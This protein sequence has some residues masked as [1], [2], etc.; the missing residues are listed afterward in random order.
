MKK[1][2]ATIL[3]LSFLACASGVI[4]NAKS[5]YA[6]ETALTQNCKSAYLCDFNS[7]ECI[8][9]ENETARMPI[10]SVCK[11]MT[12]T[13]CFDAIQSGKLSLDDKISVSE[14]AAGMG[15]SQ[16]FLQTGLTYPLSDLIK[17][18]IVCSANDSC[19]AVSESISG[20]EEG[21]VALM[22]KR[23]EELGCTDTLFANC[24]GLPKET[25]YSCAKDVAIM[26]SN[27][28][29]NEE[30]FKYSKIWLEDFNHPDNRTTSITNTNK[31]IRKYTACDGG[32][33]GFT[34]QAGF[35]LA[36]TA[37]KDSMRLVSVVLGASSS[38]DRFK[39]AMNMFDYGFANYKNRVI[40]DKDVNLNDKFTVDCSKK[41]AISVK[42]ARSSYVFSAINATP[43]IERNVIAYDIKAPVKQGDVVG[44]IEVYKDGVLC[45]TVDLVAAEDA[46][47]ATYGDFFKKVARGWTL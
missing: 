43:E 31:L 35:C 42:P 12:L 11:V 16:V 28:I 8:Y 22:N 24:T 32:K 38:D 1:L 7:G 39:S 25:Q 46:D 6:D 13:L 3:S 41:Q 19:V 4:S 47:K 9:K 2:T 33:T 37:K 30:Y 21:F 18:I 14:R 36:S 5:A 15:G 40:L 20:S 44:K 29:K 26:F 34:N 23:A 45:D 27:L 10:A 17:S